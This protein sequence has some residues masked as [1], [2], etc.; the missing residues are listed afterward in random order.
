MFENQLDFIKSEQNPNS[1]RIYFSNEINS[2]NSYNDYNKKENDLEYQKYLYIADKNRT[3][4]NNQINNE[5]YSKN[6]Q[7]DY[8]EQLDYMNQYNVNIFPNIKPNPLIYKSSTNMN[9]KKKSKSN[10]KNKYSKHDYNKNFLNNLRNKMKNQKKSKNSLNNLKSKSIVK[11]NQDQTNNINNWNQIQEPK[12]SNMKGL[13][14]P[15][16]KSN[17]L[18]FPRKSVIQRLARIEKIKNYDVKFGSKVRKL[19]VYKNLMDMFDDLTV[20]KEDK[21]FKKKEKQNLDKKNNFN[22]LS[23]NLNKCEGQNQNTDPVKN[24]SNNLDFN[25]SHQ[26][27]LIKS[28]ESQI[29]YERHMRTEINMKYLKKMKEVEQTK[30]KDLIQ[31]SSKSFSK[32]P[33]KK[34]TSKLLKIYLNEHDLISGNNKSPSNNKTNSK[35]FNEIENS[36]ELINNQKKKNLK[37]HRSQSE[38]LIKST[39]DEISPNIDKMIEKNFSKVVKNILNKNENSSTPINKNI[40][41]KFPLNKILNSKSRINIS[42]KSNIKENSNRKKID[43]YKLNKNE[44]NNNL[45]SYESNNLVN[46]HNEFKSNN[47]NHINYSPYKY[48]DPNIYSMSLSKLNLFYD[49]GNQNQTY[50]KNIISPLFSSQNNDLKNDANYNKINSQINLY[51]DKGYMNNQN[52]GPQIKNYEFSDS[53]LKRKNINNITYDIIIEMIIDDLLIENVFELQDI[54]EKEEKLKEKEN[55]KFFIQDYYKNFESF[56]NLENNVYDKLKSHDY[57]IRL[58]PTGNS[59]I[60]DGKKDR[61]HIVYKN[62]FDSLKNIEIPNINS[63]IIIE[64]DDKPKN[65]N[66]KEKRN[67]PKKDKN[68]NKQKNKINYVK[69]N[70]KNIQCKSYRNSVSPKKSKEK[71]IKREKSNSSDQKTRSNITNPFDKTDNPK[72]FKFNYLDSSLENKNIN[73]TNNQIQDKIKENFF[74]LNIKNLNN[75]IKDSYNINNKKIYYSVNF[76]KNL[77]SICENYRKSYDDYMKTTG[78]FFVPNVFMLYEDVVNKLTEELLEETLSLCIKD[79]DIMAL[80]IIRDEIEK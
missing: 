17:E 78:V 21:D 58:N 66:I 72:L 50:Y 52:I 8:Q 3:M 70:S 11:I 51:D 38:E 63:L 60:L 29:A 54:E 80:N 48:Q 76:H 67:S 61:R 18:D 34:K 40:K 74:N 64:N 71:D 28:L 15:N 73:E 44:Y 77:P 46:S 19:E 12:S 24:S 9:L 5:T 2:E 1:K 75:F 39:M 27:Q 36:I 53:M 47:I 37:N 31:M 6:M 59:M 14:N 49:L 35:Y 10:T 20:V 23:Y 56:K 32:T 30:L 13:F 26:E 4:M 68:D 69:K 45:N 22:I 65:N 41:N 79:L 7:M 57:G 16:L 55:M 33:I 62:P 42:K 25:F 43:N